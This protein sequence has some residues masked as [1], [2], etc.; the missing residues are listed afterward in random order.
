MLPVPA[1]INLGGLAQA[2]FGAPGVRRMDAICASP[3][4]WMVDTSKA[5]GRSNAAGREDGARRS[6]TWLEVGSNRSEPISNDGVNSIAA[7]VKVASSC[8]AVEVWSEGVI[9]IGAPSA[10]WVNSTEFT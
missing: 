7:I 3:P 8:T 9:E 5:G 2:A 1:K 10:A 4:S 6:I